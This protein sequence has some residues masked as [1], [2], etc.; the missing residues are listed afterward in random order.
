MST[1]MHSHSLT[2]AALAAF[3]PAHHIH[4]DALPWIPAD[5]AGKSSKPLSFMPGNSGFVELLRMDPG[6]VMPLHRHSGPIHAWNLTGSRRLCT[7]ELVG[8]GDYVYEPPGNTDWWKIEGDV[9]M[10][11]L[12][13]VHGEVEFINALGE[14]RGRA[15]AATQLQHYLAYCKQHG[16]EPVHGVVGG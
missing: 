3:A 12:V 7:G 5:T 11:A 16:I 1:A 15:T 10:I 4:A 6:V 8:P 2:P 13:I 9:P 14:V